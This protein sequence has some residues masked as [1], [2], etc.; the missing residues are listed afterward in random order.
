MNKLD[1]IIFKLKN[2]SIKIIKMSKVLKAFS[3]SNIMKS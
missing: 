2:S 3:L 1:E